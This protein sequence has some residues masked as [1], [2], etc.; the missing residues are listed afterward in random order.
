MRRFVIPFAGGFVVA[1]L[2]FVF[3]VLPRVSQERV[4]FGRRSA[5]TTTKVE[6][7]N[8]IHREL[9]NDYRDSDSTNA[10]VLFKVKDARVV[11]V[12]RDGI[13]TL[14]VR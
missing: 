9:G 7:L 5:A 6:F 3:V 12:E 14:R 13:K 4:E 10:V 8:M 11:V 2:V 1:S